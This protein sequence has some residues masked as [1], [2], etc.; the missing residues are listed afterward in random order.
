MEAGGYTPNPD[1]QETEQQGTVS[2][3]GSVHGNEYDME[4]DQDLGE[5]DG[6]KDVEGNV[7]GNVEGDVGKPS[8]KCPKRNYRSHLGNTSVPELLRWLGICV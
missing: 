2:D 7:E 1:A 3:Q 6:W 8:D 4:T 5:D